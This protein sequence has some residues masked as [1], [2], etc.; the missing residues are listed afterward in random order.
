MP[1]QN[2]VRREAIPLQDAAI[3]LDVSVKTLRRWGASSPPRISLIRV[4]PRL[5]R[6]PRDEIVRIRQT[7]IQQ[8]HV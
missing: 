8:G 6:V 2:G 1:E 5:L 4:G 3:I 7:R